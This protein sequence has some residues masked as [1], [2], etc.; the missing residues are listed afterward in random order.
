MRKKNR[1]DSG[2]SLGNA[3][4]YFKDGRL[5]PLPLFQ[6]LTLVFWIN[7]SVG[8]KLFIAGHQLFSPCEGD[9][10]FDASA[11]SNCR[12]NKV[13]SLLLASVIPSSATSSISLNRP[14]A[15]SEAGYGLWRVFLVGRRL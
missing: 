8:F 3:L 12:G 13:S 9:L 6:T 11:A 14:G 5:T 1:I 2:S 15:V 7:A 10:D 4:I